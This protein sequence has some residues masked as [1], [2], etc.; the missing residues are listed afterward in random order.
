MHT[1]TMP[2]LASVCKSE[3]FAKRA[4]ALGGVRVH[5]RR[6][7][8]CACVRAANDQVTIPGVVGAASA[9]VVPEYYYSE[10]PYPHGSNTGGRDRRGDTTADTHDHTRT[11]S[12]HVHAC[13]C[14]ICQLTQNAL[15]KASM[16][17]VLR[18]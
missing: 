1:N 18:E 10:G 3:V 16:A 14:G 9:A 7:S 2:L 12:T 5:T 11:H 4:L 13:T 6:T 8:V 15:M 17:Y